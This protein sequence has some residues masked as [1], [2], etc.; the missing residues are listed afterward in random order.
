[1]TSAKNSVLEPPNLKRLVASALA[2]VLPPLYKKPSYGPGY[3]TRPKGSMGICTSFLIR[4][5]LTAVT[6]IG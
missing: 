6:A 2:R 3:A 5:Y 4:L 1:M